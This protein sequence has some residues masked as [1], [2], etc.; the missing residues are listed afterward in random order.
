MTMD[1]AT[2]LLQLGISGVTLYILREH[3]IRTDKRIDER[4]KQTDERIDERDKAF[5]SFV[6]ANN[7]KMTELI[8][9][10]TEAIKE[11]TRAIQA[12]SELICKSSKLLEKVSEKLNH[13]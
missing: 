5:S 7:H 4:D 2:I 12:S 6:Q 8:V 11:S 9:C 3:L 10:S 13:K 1:W